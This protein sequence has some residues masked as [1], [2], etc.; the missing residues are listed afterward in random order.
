M[1]IINKI[2]AAIRALIAGPFGFPATIIM[3]IWAITDIITF[4]IMTIA[5]YHTV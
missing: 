5:Q 4:V 3:M 1:G 2:I